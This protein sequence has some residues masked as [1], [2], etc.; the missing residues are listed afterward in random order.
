MNYIFVMVYSKFN[1]L[2]YRVAGVFVLSLFEMPKCA[3]T[4]SKN[5]W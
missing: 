3:V 4:E 2:P 5:K 1:Y